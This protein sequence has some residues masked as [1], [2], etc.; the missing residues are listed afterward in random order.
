LLIEADKS[1]ATDSQLLY[2]GLF[3]SDHDKMRMRNSRV[4]AG[5]MNFIARF[6]ILLSMIA[7]GFVCLGADPACAADALSRAKQL[8]TFHFGPDD[9]IAVENTVKHLPSIRNPASPAQKL[10]VLE[11][12][13]NIYKERYRMRFIYYNSR[14]TC[15]L[16]VGQEVLEYGRF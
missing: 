12:W 8:L 11:V 16:L 7:S 1:H 15:C 13:G 5:D 14:P 6:C 4:I 3:T 9:R 2:A 10:D